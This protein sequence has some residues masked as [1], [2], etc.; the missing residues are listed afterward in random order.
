MP[1][2]AL[3]ILL[4]VAFV[5]APLLQAGDELPETVRVKV[6]RANVRAKAGLQSKVIGSAT[7]G[8]ILEVTGKAG[9]WFAVE[10]PSESGE[11]SRSGFIHERLVEPE[12]I[13]AVVPSPQP[14]PRG[15]PVLAPTPPP[16]DDTVPKKP[17]RPAKGLASTADPEKDKG[18]REILMFANVAAVHTGGSDD[19]PGSTV[20]LGQFFLNYGYFLSERNEIGGGPT[21]LLMNAGGET[22]GNLGLNAFYRRY[23]KPRDRKWA[24]FV[25]AD[26]YIQDLSPGEE[27]VPDELQQ[28]VLDVTF[29]Q[30]IAG[31]QSHLS[32]KLALDLR[33]SLGLSVGNPS[34][35]WIFQGTFGFSY[36]F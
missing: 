21:V 14:E 18:G 27:G 4:A 16:P 24:P 34:G 20:A 26:V 12:T 8:T 2:F 19:V 25:G 30:V 13:P 3:S 6:A 32:D 33:A 36:V 28:G 35:G 7:V 29:L 10:L 11:E 31:A 1:R 9:E 22:S 23:L 5:G 17:A 15:E